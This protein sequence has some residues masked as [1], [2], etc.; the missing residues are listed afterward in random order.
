MVNLRGTRYI[1]GV[2]NFTDCLERSLDTNSKLE[3]ILNWMPATDLD[4]RVS[5]LVNELDMKRGIACIFK[6]H[7][8][9]KNENVN[10]GW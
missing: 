1:F 9:V 6:F 4:I 7:V 2:S 10:F 5:L 3:V 8:D